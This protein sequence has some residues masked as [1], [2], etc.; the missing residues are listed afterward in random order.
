MYLT[1]KSPDIS[2]YPGFLQTPGINLAFVTQH[3]MLR[4]KNNSWRKL[5]EVPGVQKGATGLDTAIRLRQVLIP[6]PDHSIVGQQMS[7]FGV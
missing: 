2:Q 6:E 3:I 1:G 7:V 5:T 4:S